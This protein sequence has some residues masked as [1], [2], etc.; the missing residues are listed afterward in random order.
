MR[1]NGSRS[2]GGEEE[3]IREIACDEARIR[4]DKEGDES[5]G[6]NVEMNKC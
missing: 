5:R 2:G 4:D 1:G 3:W 6:R